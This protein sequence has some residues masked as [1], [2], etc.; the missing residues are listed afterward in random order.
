MEAVVVCI[1]KKCGHHVA[2]FVNL[3]IQVGKSYI[4]P[5]ITPTAGLDI[6]ASGEVRLGEKNTIVQD[7]HLQDI[8][9][10]RCSAVLGIR[11][12]STP[13]NHVFTKEQLLL[14]VA[15]IRITAPGS[16]IEV[17]PTVQRSLKL[18]VTNHASTPNETSDSFENT[19]R[20][21]HRQD[22]ASQAH[23]QY[24]L[25]RLITDLDAQREEIQ[26]I[27]SAGYQIVAS[28]NQA[29]HRIEIESNQLKNAMLELREDLKNESAKTSG[30]EDDVASLKSDIRNLKQ[31]LLETPVYK[32][33]ENEINATKEA[34]TNIQQSTLAELQKAAQG[35]EQEDEAIKRDFDDVRREMRNLRRE[36][37]ATKETAKES[38]LLARAY[39]KETNSL[40]AE[41]KQLKDELAAGRPQAHSSGDSIYPSREIDILTTSITKIGQRASQVETLQMELELF[42]GRVHRLETQQTKS[43]SAQERSAQ[44]NSGS[45]R[46]A[47]G[48]RMRDSEHTHETPLDADRFLSMGMSDTRNS[49]WSNSPPRHDARHDESASS[50]SP[51]ATEARDAN[52]GSL[53]FTR[54]GA[55]DKRYLKRS[56]KPPRKV[57]KTLG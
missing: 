47:P 6:I 48:K 39:G 5:V 14:R 22:T 32:R 46:A 49:I 37:D 51:T 44:Y 29:V 13:V 56:S 16:D 40:R 1:C 18:K 55:I 2:D 17:K 20:P 41:V 19:F 11:C 23:G 4:G 53:R 26:R 36:L 42:K 52:T 57:P 3:C 33:L 24:N 30:V 15:S 31:E 45:V 9:C 43:N 34:I 28:F 38:L 50:P 25:E 54:S 27:D 21:I 12:T 10:I 8:S 35:H 7:C